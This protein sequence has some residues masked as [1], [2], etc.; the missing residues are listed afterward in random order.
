LTISIFISFFLIFIS[1]IAK[2]YTIK[3]FLRRRAHSTCSM[4]SSLKVKV[5]LKNWLCCCNE[6]FGVFAINKSWCLFEATAQSVTASFLSLFINNLR[7]NTVTSY[8]YLFSPKRCEFNGNCVFCSYLY[9]TWE[10]LSNSKYDR[11]AN[12][13]VQKSSFPN[14]Q[15]RINQ[16]TE[17]TPLEASYQHVSSIVCLNIYFKEIKRSAIYQM[18]TVEIH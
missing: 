4:C 10:L 3:V 11:R 15:W 16:A 9:L 13:A 17:R 18:K 6:T 5:H 2:C 12:K 7:G 14:L 8:Q 1:F